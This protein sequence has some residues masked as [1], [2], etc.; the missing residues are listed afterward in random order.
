M[1]KGGLFYMPLISK[2]D[3]SMRKYH[4]PHFCHLSYQAC[5][6]FEAFEDSLK[7]L[8]FVLLLPIGGKYREKK[9]SHQLILSWTVS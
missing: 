9:A 5:F 7:L 8:L 6:T 4:H 2:N 1:K 3:F